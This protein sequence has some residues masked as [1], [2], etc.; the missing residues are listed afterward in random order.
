MINENTAAQVKAQLITRINKIK[1]E[2]IFQGFDY[3]TDANLEAATTAELQA[4]HDEI[5]AYA[6]DG[7]IA[8]M[9]RTGTWRA[10]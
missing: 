2:A 8:E 6:I 4:F 9:E 1:P 5:Q 7:I 3:P 10:R